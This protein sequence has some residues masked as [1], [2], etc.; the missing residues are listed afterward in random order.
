M[1]QLCMQVTLALLRIHLR[2]M[3][4]T[5]VAKARKIAME[6]LSCTAVLLVKSMP[7][8]ILRQELALALHVETT[9]VCVNPIPV[10][11]TH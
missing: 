10:I 4:E 11:S 9:T 8:A 1:Y 3:T 5:R 2:L 7:Q 6:R